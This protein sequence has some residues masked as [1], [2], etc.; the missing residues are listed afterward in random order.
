[1]NPWT[2]RFPAAI[3]LLIVV[4][5]SSRLAVA[6]SGPGYVAIDIGTLG[7][8]NTYFNLPGNTV[9]D[10]GTVLSSSDTVTPNPAR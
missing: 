1:M 10:N 2:L 6:A 5:L 8:P 9:T 3:A 4:V 7:G